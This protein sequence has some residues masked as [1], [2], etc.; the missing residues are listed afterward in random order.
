MSEHS[1]YGTTL[2]GFP[3]L[4]FSCKCGFTM[5]T[6]GLVATVIDGRCT[7]IVCPKCGFNPVAESKIQ[8]R[9]DQ[10]RSVLDE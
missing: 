9:E 3:K 5:K 10:G 7:K 8:D 4:V 6:S 1:K 2:S